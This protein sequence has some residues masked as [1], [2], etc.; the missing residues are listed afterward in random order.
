MTHV[1]PPADRPDVVFISPP[2]YYPWVIPPGVAYLAGYLERFGVPTKVI[3]A[4]VEGLEYLLIDSSPTPKKTA[5]AVASLRTLAITK[6]WHLYEEATRH[7]DECARQAS[8][9]GSERI[10]FSRNTFR[11]YP[12]YELRSGHGLLL[13]A[14]EWAH[15]LFSPYYVNGLLPQLERLRPLLVAISATDLHQLLPATVICA[16]LRDYLGPACP[17]L[18]L[19][20]NVFARVYDSL[21]QP[22][23][24]NESLLKLWGTVIVGEGERAL[25]E[26]VQTLRERRSIEN[27]EGAIRLGGGRPQ[28]KSPLPLEELASPRCDDFRPLIPLKPVPLNIYRG[29]YYAGVCTFCDINQGYDS[30]WMSG[31]PKLSNAQRRFRGVDLIVEDIKSCM[32]DYETTLFNFTDEWF[33]ARD[34]VA[35]SEE[36][37]AQ[38]VRIQWD[39]YC[40]LEPALAQ[41]ATAK[42]LARAGARFFQFGL[43]SATL[44]TLTSVGKGI[45]PETSAQVLRCLAQAGIWNHVFLIVG[46][47]GEYLHQA[48]LTIAFILDNADHLL[49]I[50]PTRFQL[51]RHSPMA[52]TLVDP[53]IEPAPFREE[54]IDLALNLPFQYRSFNFCARCGGGALASARACPSCKDQPVSRPLV[55]RR[56]V[57]LMYT[58]MELVAANHWAYPFTSLYPYHTRMLFNSEDARRIAQERSPSTDR[59]LGRSQADIS[60]TLEALCRFLQWEAR[61]IEAV[62]SVYKASGLELPSTWQTVAD[63]EAFALRWARA[64]SPAEIAVAGAQGETLHFTHS[65]QRSQRHPIETP[66]LI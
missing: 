32:R 15:H 54:A 6:D 50:K 18:M 58:A 56:A 12:A 1:N 37:I 52:K 53:H 35:L 65:A 16:V 10:T 21:S 64:C 60:K 59:N 5:D 43:E 41:P 13:A 20:G 62:Q 22:N 47:P 24:I 14:R 31:S 30:I 33:L 34:M 57:N 4:N 11:Y 2:A 44:Q 42:L 19:G 49:T 17:E 26:S 36:L 23:D 45:L 55:S 3:D 28:K 51:A 66:T 40:R 27:A 39:A 7:L 29:C 61:H 38:G 8:Q 48:L 9:A 63:I 46:I 25:L